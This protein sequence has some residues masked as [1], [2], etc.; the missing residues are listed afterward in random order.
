M[1]GIIDV[2]HHWVPPHHAKDLA[3]VALPGQT[4]REIKP[5]TM[6]LFHGPS[7]RRCA[8]NGRMSFGTVK[9]YCRCGTGRSTH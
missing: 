2:H 7:D 5:G 9:T 1:S 6:G 3:R 4:V 8:K